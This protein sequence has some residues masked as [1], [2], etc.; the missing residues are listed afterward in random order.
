MSGHK[1][2]KD[3]KHKSTPEQRDRAR[4]ELNEE[5]SLH[6][7]RK[8]RSMTQTNLAGAL[9]MTQPG[10]SRIERQTDLYVSTLRS[11][12][13]ALGGE[14]ELRAWFPDAGEVKLISIDQ[15]DRTDEHAVPASL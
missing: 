15:L 1:S 11:Y 14:L 4:A 5:L 6:E 12:V 8:A 7:L 2:W 9:E 13:E 3:I 10:I